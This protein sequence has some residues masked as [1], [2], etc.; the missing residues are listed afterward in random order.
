MKIVNLSYKINSYNSLYICGKSGIGKTSYIINFLK[1]RDYHYNYIPIQSLKT[2][3]EWNEL[4]QRRNV[5]SMFNKKKNKKEVILIDNIDYLQNT[6][7]KMIG[8]IT[9]YL[10]NISNEE[11]NG[12]NNKTHTI[13][14]V[15]NNSTDKKVLELQEYVDEVFHIKDKLVLEHHDKHMKE[16][17]SDLLNQKYDKKSQINSEKTIVS[18]CFHENIIHFI[19]NNASIYS[20]V[21]RNICIGDYFDRIAFQKQLWQ[22]NEMTYYLKVVQNYDIYRTLKTPTKKCNYHDII[23][24]KILTKYSNEYANCNYIINLC[25]KFEMQKYEFIKK[26]KENDENLLKY[27]SSLEKKRI[28]KLIS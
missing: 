13:I 20:K 18:L 2:E 27:L 15:G 11:S 3:K 16:I 8:I 1:S 9:K 7:K 6:D 19:G 10:K 24:T 21:L 26:F 5:L 28:Q 25:N 22:F 4:F 14:F 17:V 23:F 12:K